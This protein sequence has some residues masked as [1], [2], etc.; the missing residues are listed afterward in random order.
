MA[1]QG[2]VGPRPIQALAPH[3]SLANDDLEF[4]C[5]AFKYSPIMNVPR[6]PRPESSTPLLF[7][8]PSDRGRWDTLDV[9]VLGLLV[10][11]DYFS[12]FVLF[13]F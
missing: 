7:P 11:K 9:G 2:H 6:L 12:R 1:D 13:V 10:N 8:N 3:V 5:K 4:H